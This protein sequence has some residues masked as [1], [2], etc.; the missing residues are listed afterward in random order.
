MIYL[1]YAADFAAARGINPDTVFKVISGI[2]MMNG[3]PE[4][5]ISVAITVP[6]VLAIRKVQ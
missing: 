2:G 1:L 6:V 5:I 4:A 3:I